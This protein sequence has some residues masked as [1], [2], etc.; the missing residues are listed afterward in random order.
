MKTLTTLR[1][2]ALLISLLFASLLSSRAATVYENYTFTTLAGSTPGWHDGVGS[3]AGF[4]YP[5]SVGVDAAGNT[6]ISDAGNHTIRKISPGGLVTTLA[7]LAGNSGTADGIGGAARFNSPSGVAVGADGTVYVADTQNHAVR[8]ISTNGVVTTL[9]GLA[10]TSGKTEGT[11]SAARFYHPQDVA[12]D[13]AGNVYVADTYNSSI[14]K[15]TPAGVVTTLAGLSGSN[16]NANGTGST[17]RFTRPYGI[18]TDT[19]GNIFVGD[20]YNHTVR[21]ITSAGVV[22]TL[23]GSAGSSGSADGTNSTARFY[24]PCGLSVDGAGNIFV[25]DIFNNTIR[26]ITPEGVVT[27]PVGLAKVTGA[28][29]GTGNAARFN[30]PESVAVG[31]GTNLYVADLNNHTIRKITPDWVVTTLAGI[32]SGSGTN[33]GLGLAA[34]FNYPSGLVVDTNGNT[35]VADLSN[36]TIRKI[37]PDGTVTT[38]AGAAGVSGAVDGT[39]SAARFYYPI[40]LAL[41]ADGTLY[42]VE[43]GNS[44]IR[45]IDSGG[46]VTTLA[47]GTNIGSANGPGLSARFNQPCGIA[48]DTNGTVYVGDTSNNEIRKITPDGTVSTLVG[49]TNAGFI[50]GV[51]TSARFSWPQGLAFDK[52]G[53]LL[54]ADAKNNMIRKV[55]LDGSVTTIAGATNSG[56]ADGVGT[57]ARFH[58]PFGLAIDRT[59]NIFVSDSFTNTI[60]KITPEGNVTTIGGA[61]GTAS[62]DD[63]TGA[64]ARFNTPEGLAVD[65]FG[66]LYVADATSQLVRKGSPALADWPMVDLPA[67]AAV[68]SIRHLSDTNAAATS[69]NWRF[70][71]YPA[72][73]LAQ[74]SSTNAANSSFT[75]DVA[76][77]YVVRL[78]AADGQGHSVIAGVSVGADAIAPK[79]TIA[80]PTSGQ[81]TTNAV[82][83]ASGTASD[84]LTTSSVWCQVGNGD[85]IQATGTSSW[86]AN[87]P[88]LPG[89]N[90]IRAYAVD[91]SGNHSA[92]QTVSC[93]YAAFTPLQVAINGKGTVAPNYNGQSLE[94]TKAYKMTASASAGF[95]FRSWSGG[96]ASSTATLKFLMSSNLTLTANFK[97]VLRPNLGISY[98]KPSQLVSNALLVASGAASDNYRLASVWYRLNSGSWLQIVGT[99]KWSTALLTLVPGT[100]ILQ[101]YAADIDG[102][103]SVTSKVAFTYVLS[104]PLTLAISGQ[105]TLSPN[106]SNALLQI[107]KTYKITAKPGLGNV[108]SNWTGLFSTNATTLF[109]TMQSNLVLQANFVPNPFPHL[110]GNYAG[111][112]QPTNGI[113]PANAGYFAGKIDGKGNFSG[114]LTFGTTTYP[115]SGP[116]GVG[117]TWTKSVT[118]PGKTTLA[119]QLQADL[120][121]G[122]ALTGSVSDGVWMANLAAFRAVY[123]ATNPAPQS[124][125]RYTFAIPGSDDPAVAPAGFGYGW[126]TSDVSGNLTMGGVLGDGSAFSRSTTV[127]RQGQWPFFASVNSAAGIIIGWMTFTN[128]VGTDLQGTLSWHRNAQTTAKLYPAGFDLPAVEMLGSAYVYSNGL[129][130]LNSTNGQLFLTGGNLPQSVTNAYTLT[131]TKITGPNLL[132]LTAT[133]VNGLFRGTVTNSSSRNPVTVSGALLQKQNAGYGYFSGTNQTGSVFLKSE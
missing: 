111:L 59:G 110:Q 42:V 68:G 56:S 130:L 85:W 39:G 29:D 74:L 132:S 84:D 12:V 11:G 52:E 34:K 122:E 103:L 91:I 121:S 50:N 83:G 131:G 114:S 104:A 102:N 33:D 43:Y 28:V 44:M 6:V 118:R 71:R 106:Y 64:Q 15:I 19:A 31:P 73:S 126:I 55:A 116:L 35:F 92:T 8:K 97:D 21:K 80:S 41:G 113:T 100:N 7:G 63:G 53:N 32:P 133:N 127:A 75:P 65:Q 129:P 54:V 57:A 46:T 13:L 87:L 67:S 69:W 10:G 3:D 45:K 47:G 49:S 18:T 25:A 78:Q 95:K 4:H 124:G 82:F 86:K 30:N 120:A 88:L 62:G 125:H 38:I 107:G 89:T 128:D 51:G 98:P 9:A 70:I 115:L 58:H 36:H 79:M 26:K 40:A 37:A 90:L 20:T 17:A 2:S 76:D 1:C 109:F 117:G 112:F 123:A 105:G 14:R 5:C 24:Y 119:V 108:F 48:V 72:T 101:A 61:P 93:Y 99:N 22:T 77:V 27:T 81:R 23:A 94:I 60:R 96:A 66:N 16:G